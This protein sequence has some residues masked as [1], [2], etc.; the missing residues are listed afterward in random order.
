MNCFRKFKISSES[1]K[2][3]IAED[4]NPF[5]ELEEK[6]QNLLSIQPDLVSENM[7]A[8]FFTDIDAEVLIVQSQP[9]DAEI[10]AELLK[11]EDVSNDNDDVIET[12]DEPVCIPPTQ[13][14]LCKLL[15][16]CKNSPYFQKVVQLF[17][18]MRIMFPT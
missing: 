5:K 2:V 8:A 10:V 6:I 3:T 11:M 17:N 9:S 16:P 4:D 1:Q 15:R 7:D 12:E 14:N 13:M 18:L